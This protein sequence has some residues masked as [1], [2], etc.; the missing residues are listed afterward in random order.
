MSL[1]LHLRPG[2][3]A[4]VASVYVPLMTSPDTAR[5]KFYEDLHTLLAT[6][7]KTD[8][9]IA[10]GDFNARVGTDHAVWRGL[11][12]PSGSQRLQ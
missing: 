11:L 12:G 3:C 5:N 1:R 8:K 9:L 7:P 2:K 10:L 6:V 4:S